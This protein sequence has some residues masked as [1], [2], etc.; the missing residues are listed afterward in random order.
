VDLEVGRP[1]FVAFAAEDVAE[2]GG[3]GATLGHELVYGLG[4]TEGAANVLIRVGPVAHAV[5]EWL[6][7]GADGY[8]VVRELAERVFGGKARLELEVLVP[9]REIPVCTLGG[10][11]GVQ[12][13]VDTRVVA[14]RMGTVRVRVPLGPNVLHSARTFVEEEPELDELDTTVP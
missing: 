10:E 8:D 6:M 2:L 1:S 4:T 12:L 14:R 9:S 7:P 13:G 3:A 5:Y 11:F